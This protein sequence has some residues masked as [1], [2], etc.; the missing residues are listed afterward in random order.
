MD[1]HLKPLSE[2]R[3]K[4]EPKPLVVSARGDVRHDV[5]PLFIEPTRSRDLVEPQPIGT[6]DQHSHSDAQVSDPAWVFS[7]RAA[8]HSH[9]FVHRERPIS[10]R[11][12]VRAVLR[13]RLH[14]RDF[15]RGFFLSQRLREPE[16]GQQGSRA[17]YG[18]TAD[19]LHRLHSIILQHYG[20]KARPAVARK[21]TMR[22]TSE[23]RIMECGNTLRNRS[24]SEPGRPT[25]TAATTSDCAAI[26]FPITP[27]AEFAAAMSTGG[28]DRLRAVI[29]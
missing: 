29:T 2:Q 17:Q 14:R 7:S 18:D 5:I 23:A 28:K 9:Q 20:T 12:Q 19:W 1:L 15:K 26:I 10:N 24:P 16:S 13:D 11:Q 8:P 4:H 6:P 22:P 3:P 25:A 27:P 21:S